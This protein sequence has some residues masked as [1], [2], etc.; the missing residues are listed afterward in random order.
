M[1][2][3]LRCRKAQEEFGFLRKLF[4]P[5]E[6]RA[7]AS[8]VCGVRHRL[9]QLTPQRE[10]EVVVKHIT[11]PGLM[12]KLDA[13][14]GSI[15]VDMQ[16]QPSYHSGMRLAKVVIGGPRRVMVEGIR[17]IAERLCS[18]VAASDT[19]D[20]MVRAVKTERP[21]AAIID[22]SSWDLEAVIEQLTF[23]APELAIVAFVNSAN[24]GSN[25]ITPKMRDIKLTRLATTASILSLEQAIK[26][27]IGSHRL[28]AGPAN[29]AAGLTPAVR[30]TER[31]R[32]VLRLVCSAEPTKQI[33]ETLG[34]SVRT[35][36]F[37]KYRLMKRLRIST[38]SELIL[39]SLRSGNQTGDVSSPPSNAERTSSA[40]GSF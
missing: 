26:D 14:V 2:G 23:S 12:C 18:V 35:V 16:E 36:E 3:P 11:Q 29:G 15:R 20:D 37:H 9:L 28:P 19:V 7:L 4:T 13:I 5:A 1:H 40:A 34:V 17:A 30:L 39:W 10:R 22:G 25:G 8:K 6:L 33:A 38:V 27:A 21:V 32:E 24:I 31:Q